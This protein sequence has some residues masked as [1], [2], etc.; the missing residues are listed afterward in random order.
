MLELNLEEIWEYSDLLLLFVK[1][2]ITT[3]YKQTILGPLWL[4]LQPVLTTFV[5]TIIF[6]NIAKI[7]TDGIPKP[8]F[9]MAGIVAW[10][11][12][13]TC[14]INTSN[15]LSGNM[16]LFGKVYFP[17]VIAPM[18]VVLSSLLRF[19]IQFILFGV[20]LVYYSTFT[21]YISQGINFYNILLLPIL[22]I[23]MGFQGLGFGLILSSLTVKYR[24]VKYLINFGVRLL[25]YASPVIFPLSMVPKN[26]LSII[27]INP[28]TAIIEAFR[29]I[30]LGQ[31]IINIGFLTYPIIFTIFLFSIG[32]IIFNQI[33]KNF[34]DSV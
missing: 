18:S 29:S 13:S 25:M 9:Y 22:I 2:D 33:E 3:Q 5:F 16:H 20:L 12:F 17:R 30:F 11:Y 21:G 4:F 7:P 8:L 19:F 15:S 14:L 26:Y 6:G 28:M 23:L 31:D 24:D 32:L 10:N 27:L 34:I 1:R